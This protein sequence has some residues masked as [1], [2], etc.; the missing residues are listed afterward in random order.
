MKITIDGCG[1]LE[2]TPT[3]ILHLMQDAWRFKKD[4]P[5]T[6][7]EYIEIIQQTT[8]RAFGIGI[9]V[10]GETI[11]EKADSL[12]RNMAAHGIIKIEGETQ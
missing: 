8:W 1:S 4:A 6:V 2:G 12:L 11:E 10:T 9:T 7:E 5:K 3:T